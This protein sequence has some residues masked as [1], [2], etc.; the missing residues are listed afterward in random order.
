MY[1]NVV[2]YLKNHSASEVNKSMTT[3]PA[4]PAENIIA[5]LNAM[6]R[7]EPA[8]SGQREDIF[9]VGEMGFL[10][11]PH[12]ELAA[13][14]RDLGAPR[15][16]LAQTLWGSGGYEAKILSCLLDDPSKLTEEQMATWADSFDSWVVCDYCCNNLLWQARFAMKKAIEWAGSNREALQ[17]A[18]FSL[19][20]ALAANLA[21]DGED[22]GFFDTALFYARKYASSPNRH[23]Q[24]SVSAALQQ[25]GKRNAFWH[26]TVVETAEE[27]AMQPSESS[28]WVASQTFAELK[29]TRILNT[30]TE[31]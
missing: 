5:R 15:H 2:Y 18:G 19:I 9:G 13:L 11:I 24:R 10:N 26:E 25:I 27:I 20:A 21:A 7:R 30:I 29:S 1:Y 12:A 31:V 14:A 8:D 28:R 23:V 17:Y 4:N 3:T 22:L 6:A 16:D